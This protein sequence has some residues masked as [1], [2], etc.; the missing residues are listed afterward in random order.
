ME[1]NKTLRVGEVGFGGFVQLRCD[2]GCRV[3]GRFFWN[4]GGEGIVGSLR[5]Y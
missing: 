5:A 2:L 4:E 1:A 3:K